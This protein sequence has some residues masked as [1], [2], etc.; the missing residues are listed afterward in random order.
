M[1]RVSTLAEP[2]TESRMETL[3]RLVVVQSGLPA[4]EAQVEIYD[5]SGDLVARVDFY[6]RRQRLALEY[7]GAI[8]KDQL[9]EDNRRQNR[10]MKLGIR[11]LRFT[12]GDVLSHPAIVVAQVRA[13]LAA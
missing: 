13:M 3:L 5:D 11:L 1:R 2:K 8:H 12:A 6:Y 10:L 7:D 4:P 9:A